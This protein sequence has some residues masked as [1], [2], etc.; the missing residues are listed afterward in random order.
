MQHV[1]ELDGSGEL[2]CAW[3]VL[4]NLVGE[5]RYM[6]FR[7][8]ANGE[9]LL[10]TDSTMVAM[11]AAGAGHARLS[12]TFHG[13]FG[14]GLSVGLD[15]A[16][17]MRGTRKGSWPEARY[18]TSYLRGVSGLNSV[19]KTAGKR[20]LTKYEHIDPGMQCEHVGQDGD[21]CVW[22]P[23]RAGAHGGQLSGSLRQL[24]ARVR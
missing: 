15:V 11:N 18:T 21:R 4:I 14:N 24:P 6:T 20:I 7:V 23:R 19:L 5:D 1:Q 13:R 8:G 2:S 3:R 9:E 22:A 12:N 16:L 10:T 17:P